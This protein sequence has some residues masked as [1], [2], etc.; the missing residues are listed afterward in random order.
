MI[1]QNYVFHRFHKFPNNILENK[2]KNEYNLALLYMFL[3]FF[4]MK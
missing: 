3:D 4:K 1:L 2:T